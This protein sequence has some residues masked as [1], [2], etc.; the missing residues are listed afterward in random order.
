MVLGLAYHIILDT[1]KTKVLN[2]TFTLQRL[3]VAY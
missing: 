2:K 1:L 3:K